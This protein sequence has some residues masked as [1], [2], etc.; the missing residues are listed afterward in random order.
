MTRR[1]FGVSRWKV[2][3]ARLHASTHGAAADVPP[4]VVSYHIKPEAASAI[5]AFAN[6]P[7]H[8]QL[9][10]HN[11]GASHLSVALKEVPK[12]LWAKYEK[13][14]SD[15]LR[16]CR[17]SFLK[18]FNQPVFC[19]MRGKS[20]L[21]GPCTEHGSQVSR[22]PCITPTPPARD[23]APRLPHTPRAARRAPLT[24]F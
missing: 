3:S 16:V 24:G 5:N 18:F 23:A 17:S 12:K 22:P 6:D 13:E 14:V 20:C 2:Y 15:D 9:L 11:K 8:V 19:L 10:A 4:A 7:S 21:C 1:L